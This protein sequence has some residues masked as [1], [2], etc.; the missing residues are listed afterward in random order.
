MII[1]ICNCFG[2]KNLVELFLLFS[3]PKNEWHR[4]SVK[5]PQKVDLHKSCLP[6]KQ[7]ILTKSSSALKFGELFD[8]Q[9]SIQNLYGIRPLFNGCIVSSIHR[10]LFYS[11]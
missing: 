1:Q 11:K 5:D 7:E 4:K 6:K 9:K 3:W 10:V 2:E 8:R